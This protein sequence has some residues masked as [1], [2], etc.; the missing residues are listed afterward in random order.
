MV[1]WTSDRAASVVVERLREIGGF[2]R[3]RRFIAVAG[4][5]L[6]HFERADALS[7]GRVGK[8]LALIEFESVM[9]VEEVR[10][11]IGKGELDQV[12]WYRLKRMYDE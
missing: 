5:T 7:D 10:G 3:V 4:T 6:E 9:D 8:E 12:G 11:V 2:K 1:S